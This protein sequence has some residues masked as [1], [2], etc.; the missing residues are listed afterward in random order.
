M[1]IPYFI[2]PFICQ[3]TFGLLPLLTIVNNYFIEINI[4]HSAVSTPVYIPRC[5]LSRSYDNSVFNFL[6]NG[7]LFFQWLCYL[8]FS[9][10]MY[11]GSK[12]STSLWTPVTLFCL[13][14]YSHPSKCEVVSH[15][16]LI[17]ISLMML[18][19]FYGFIT[20]LH[21]FFGKIIKIFCPFH[22]GHLSF[23]CYIIKVIYIFYSQVPFLMSD[24]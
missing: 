7:Q 10:T 2:Y 19:S 11:E 6:R 8:T 13:F 15:L 21:I 24:L 16:V 4:W 14:D 17:C 3:W 22:L 18:S 12:F 20:H 23:Y 9:L 1:Y 5:G